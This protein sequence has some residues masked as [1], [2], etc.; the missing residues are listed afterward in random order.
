VYDFAQQEV[1][2]FAG[3]ERNAY[4]VEHDFFNPKGGLF[5]QTPWRIAGGEVGVFGHVGITHREPSDAE[6]WDTW[7]GP[8]D[9]GADPLF[10]ARREVLD[11]AGNVAYVQWSD[12]LVEA[13]RVVDW[14]GGV[15]VRARRLSFTLNGYW[16]D[17]E[18]E[19]VPSGY[20][21]PDRGVLRGNA[22][23]TLHR[24]VE[25][26][27]RWQPADD[28]GLT[29]GAS[30]SWNEYEEFIFNDYDWDAGEVV[31][32]DFSGNPI[33]LFPDRLVSA[34]WS[35]TFGGVS[36]DLQV[37]HVG[38]QYLDNTGDEARTIDPST[39]CDVALF[40]DL[41]AALRGLS[42]KVRI[43]NLFAEE[44][45]TW[46]YHDPFGAGNYKLPAATRNVLAGVTY[47]F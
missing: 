42:A 9:L 4:G 8:D 23:R 34:T 22:D 2:N 44:Y 32:R 37:R 35:S 20:Y 24:G 5:W 27:L 15:A 10:A 31:P 6:Y 19:I 30:R 39:V 36:A 38:K 26:G 21:D 47:D 41:D 46:G 29:V 7:S 3:A 43:Q 33:P 1:A 12:P 13:E 28:H 14:E 16:M 18:H 11:A 45:E 17:F 40:W 25:L